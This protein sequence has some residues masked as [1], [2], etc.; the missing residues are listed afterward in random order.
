MAI[1]ST[2][3]R[4]L[5]LCTDIGR[6]HPFYL[7]GLK[8]ELENLGPEKA[9]VEYGRCAELSGPAGKLAWTMIGQLYRRG[10]SPGAWS[11]LYRRLR[12]DGDYNRDG[13]VLT[14]LRRSL[15][16]RLAPWRAADTVVAHPLL[17]AVLRPH[18]RV[19][20]QHGELMT[21]GE[22]VVRGAHRVLVPTQAASLPFLEAGYRPDQLWI[23]GLCIEPD[24]VLQ[25]QACFEHRLR[26]LNQGPLTGAFFTSGAEP[27]LH[28]ESIAM[29]L[30]SVLAIGYAA[31]VYA[32]RGGRLA[33]ALERVKS[34]AP[35]GE[36][37]VC[38]YSS[39]T[40]LD[41]LTAHHF[42]RF[43]YLVSP[44][45]ERTHWALGL[46]LPMFI[47]GPDV[48]PFAPLNREL[49]L[50]EGVAQPLEGSEPLASLLARLQRQGEL[51]ERAR[52]GWGRLP[53]DGF[54]R[55]AR[56]LAASLH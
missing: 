29:A 16:H 24:L 21:P 42:H 4:I 2:P 50:R 6:G 51:S 26:R 10:S 3:R 1:A 30:S 27:A 23:T 40:E 54:A 36:L 55:G 17:V 22:A 45:H 48:G 12:K 15:R 34:H 18:P 13:L 9:V 35:L 20:Y 46:G 33:A 38:L 25:S 28:V 56:L 47:A 44:P 5:C 7:D 52:R 11:G 39:R 49:L 19:Y 41:L 32:A 8:R 31:V 37:T 43:D 53:L 14:L